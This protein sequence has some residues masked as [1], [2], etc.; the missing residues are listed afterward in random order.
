[1]PDRWGRYRRRPRSVPS[2]CHVG[3]RF[4][5]VGF[6]SGWCDV[7][8]LVLPSLASI[9]VLSS[10][11]LSVS[12]ALLCFCRVQVSLF[13]LVFCEPRSVHSILW[14]WWGSSHA[15][16]RGETGMR[17]ADWQDP[18]RDPALS[19]PQ[20]SDLSGTQ[21]QK[22]GKQAWKTGSVLVIVKP[23]SLFK[24]PVSFYRVWNFSI[25][26][27]S[28]SLPSVSSCWASRA[29]L[30]LFYHRSQSGCMSDAPWFLLICSTAEFAKVVLFVI[31]V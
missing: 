31:C 27:D 12:V 22:P 29:R 7:A 16:W 17:Q 15:H 28:P 3:C 25:L 2:P 20:T 10:V 9:P 1:M 14:G 26:R 24:V 11:W 21:K 13:F 6:V 23:L 4:W 30:L 19:A 5:C 8:L 18:P